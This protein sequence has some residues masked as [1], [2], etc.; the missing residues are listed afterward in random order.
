M[1]QYVSDNSIPRAGVTDLNTAT[2]LTSTTHSQISSSLRP[3]ED[4]SRPPRMAIRRVRGMSGRRMPFSC[5]WKENKKNDNDD[6][7]RAMGSSENMGTEARRG[8]GVEGSRDWSC[9]VLGRAAIGRVAS[10]EL[11]IMMI[12]GNNATSVNRVAS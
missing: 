8:A 10:A 5:T 7:N 9:A 3:A 2:L 1:L 4:P 6:V 12:V 11:R